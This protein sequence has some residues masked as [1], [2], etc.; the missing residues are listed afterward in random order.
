M[1]NFKMKKHVFENVSQVLIAHTKRIEYRFKTRLTALK[2][3]HAWNSRLQCSK[4]VN[5]HSLSINESDSLYLI[6]IF[7]DKIRFELLRRFRQSF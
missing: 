3:R 2:T 1:V 5:I 4:S 6:I 7:S